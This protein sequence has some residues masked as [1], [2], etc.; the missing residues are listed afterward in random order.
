MTTTNWGYADS[1]V[2]VDSLPHFAIVRFLFQLWIDFGSF[3]RQIYHFLQPSAQEVG[4]RASRRVVAL[5]SRQV[6][7]NLQDVGQVRRG[8]S[9]N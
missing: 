1:F 2:F 6:Y 9:A 7:W 4:G 3:E 5:A 8:S